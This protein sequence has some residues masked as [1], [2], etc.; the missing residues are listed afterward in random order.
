VN[1][2]LALLY[3]EGLLTG[4]QLLNRLQD[5]GYRTVLVS[6]PDRLAE[7]ALAD[8]PLLVA[9][10]LAVRTDQVCEAIRQLK[11]HESTAHVPVLAYAK[12]GT[13]KGDRR[14]ADAARG[15]GI[16]LLANEAGLLAQLPQL[17]DQVLQVE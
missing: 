8:L 10:E 11:R 3:Y 12:L 16:N 17:L 5:Q 14:F 13:G 2:P 15:A 7:Q 4:S 6:E 9:V 1:N